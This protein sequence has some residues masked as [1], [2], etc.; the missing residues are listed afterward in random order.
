[1]PF[2]DNL[3]S[4]LVLREELKPMLRH[5]LQYSHIIN[6]YITNAVSSC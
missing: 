3:P 6:Y 1:M 2:L 5:E 4:F